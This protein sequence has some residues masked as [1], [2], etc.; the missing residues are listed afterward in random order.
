MQVIYL[1]RKRKEE[2]MDKSLLEEKMAK[3]GFSNEELANRLGIDAA[4]FYRKKKGESDFYRREIQI[5]K[6]LLQ[7]SNEEVDI[8]FFAN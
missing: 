2:S 6:K 7:L 5:I 8:I 1:L 3:N 4:T